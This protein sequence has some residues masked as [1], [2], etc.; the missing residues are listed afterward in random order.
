MEGER[1]RWKKMSLCKERTEKKNDCERDLRL[2]INYQS[3][4]TLL[5]ESLHFFAISTT[6]N[7]MLLVSD[8]KREEGKERKV[9][10]YNWINFAFVKLRHQNEFVDRFVE[11]GN[12]FDI[13]ISDVSGC[14]MLE[15][16]I[17]ANT[18]RIFNEFAGCRISNYSHYI[19]QRVSVFCVISYWIIVASRDDKALFWLCS[20]CAK[21]AQIIHQK[22]QTW[23]DSTFLLYS[24]KWRTV[25]KNYSTHNL[26]NSRERPKKLPNDSSFCF[27]NM[28]ITL[29]NVIIVIL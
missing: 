18:L 8:I 26:H 22:F 9:I 7:A 5:C 17:F 29:T 2:V 4:I 24:S 15:T 16:D 11:I 12:F 14:V 3:L 28:Y 19:P 27:Q 10:F 13:S 23:H 6:D 20:N 1:E 25:R 21:N